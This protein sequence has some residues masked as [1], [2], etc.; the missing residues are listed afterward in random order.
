[1]RRF[2]KLSVLKPWTMRS[3][4]STK[5]EDWIRELLGL[6]LVM[7]DRWRS[8]AGRVDAQIPVPVRR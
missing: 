1:M 4:I 7:D 5:M 6:G 8:L 2:R 3:D